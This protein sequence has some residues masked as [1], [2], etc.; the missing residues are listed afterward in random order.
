MKVT[1][2]LYGQFLLS[3]QVNY[4]GTYLADHLAG[5]THDNVAY[6]L[7]TSRF[8]PRQVWQKVRHLIEWS[9]NGYIIFDDTVLDKS[10][11]QQIELVRR[12]YSGNA[13][14]VIKGIGVVNCL[15]VNPETNQ[16]WLIDYRIFQPDHD[17]KTKID[18]VLEML[19][20]LAPRGVRY[21]TVLMDSWYAVTA[22]FKWIIAAE[23]IFYCPI[24]S[25]RKVDDSGGQAPYQPV[26]YLS[27]SASE[28]VHGKRIKLH[29]MP[30]ATSFH[31]FR[32][33][34]STRQTDYLITNEIA[35]NQTSAAEEKCD[36]R[37]RIEQLHREL[38][39]VT[40]IEKCQCRKGRSQ[41]N[42]LALATLVWVRLKHLAYQAKTTVY[43]LKQGLL[44]DY[45]RRELKT[46]TLA[47]A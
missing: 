5:L 9:P 13:K 2:Q 6:F 38:K 31:L 42:H 26:S 34:V 28:V 40:G 7:K 3:S 39:Q 19:A 8:A 25:N 16:F 10:H 22:I 45:M 35:Q 29:G 11:S 4:T 1:A 27:W 21:R 12:Q 24:K 33:L 41:R 32:V 18:H 23:K 36:I 15:Y 14:G 17:G 30:Q 46:P 43:Q 44:S 20:Q 47:F 37:W